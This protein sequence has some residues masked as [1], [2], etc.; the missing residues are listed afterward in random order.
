MIE[1]RLR[2]HILLGTYT[3]RQCRLNLFAMEPYLSLVAYRRVSCLPLMPAAIATYV[4][5][6]DDVKLA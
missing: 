1:K 5:Y 4:V 3:N 2:T 6:K